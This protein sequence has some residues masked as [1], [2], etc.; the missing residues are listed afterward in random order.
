[1]NYE[2]G[3]FGGII[4]TEEKKED[5]VWYQFVHHKTHT[6]LSGIETGPSETS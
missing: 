1:V 6:D 4:V 5:F 3:A 2:Y